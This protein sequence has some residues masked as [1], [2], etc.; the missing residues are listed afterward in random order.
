MSLRKV[1]DAVKTTLDRDTLEGKVYPFDFNRLNTLDSE[2]IVIPTFAGSDLELVESYGD[3][4]I[5]QWIIAVNIY[6]AITTLGPEEAGY[7]LVDIVE[8]VVA[9][10]EQRPHLGLGAETDLTIRPISIIRVSPAEID[11]QEPDVANWL[12]STVFLKV[13]EAEATQATE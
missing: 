5:R 11:Q 7:L 9:S 2:S 4:Y 13:P 6:T 3:N 1:I 12:R 8:Q 10:F